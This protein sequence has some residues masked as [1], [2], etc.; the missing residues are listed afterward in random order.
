MAI[1]LLRFQRRNYPNNPNR[2][3]WIAALGQ[4]RDLGMRSPRRGL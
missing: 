4:R 1:D 3:G 2:Y